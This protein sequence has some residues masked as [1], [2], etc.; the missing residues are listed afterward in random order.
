[1]VICNLWFLWYFYLNVWS[2][3]PIQHISCHT[4]FC[5][6][7]MDVIK[8]MVKPSAFI[9]KLVC[10]L[11]YKLLYGN[12]II[13]MLWNKLLQWNVWLTFIELVMHQVFLILN[14][15]LPLIFD[16]ILIFQCPPC[17]PYTLW[18]MI[19]FKRCCIACTPSCFFKI[20]V[21]FMYFRCSWR[22]LLLHW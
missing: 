21:H 14:F 7:A 11:M 4:K 2:F 8:Y 17:S 18:F 22:M 10:N 3:F 13:S 15:R 6:I 16:I 12:K 20:L 5:I 19:G 1:M 9:W